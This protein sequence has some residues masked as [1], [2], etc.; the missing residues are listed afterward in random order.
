MTRLELN[1]PYPSLTFPVSEAG[2]F[3]IYDAG[4]E[5]RLFFKNPSSSEVKDI[6]NGVASFAL[7]YHLDILF[8]SYRFGTAPWSEAAFS[9]WLVPE[10]R[11][12]QLENLFGKQRYL[13]QVVLVDADTG[14]IKVLRAITLTPTM[15]H[16]LRRLYL[17][18]QDS[19]PVDQAVYLERCNQVYQIFPKS[20]TLALAATA[21]Q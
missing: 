17:E 6:K 5:L 8:L 9:Y 19:E 21:K 12:T 7:S 4:L 2:E 15:S 16:E 20:D 11:R 14:L 3:L 13:L 18:Q 1:H 10:D